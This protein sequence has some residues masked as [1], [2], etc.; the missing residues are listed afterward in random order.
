[1][2]DIIPFRKANAHPQRSFRELLERR[3]PGYVARLLAQGGPGQADFMAASDFAK[4]ILGPKG[5]EIQFLFEPGSKKQ[6]EVDTNLDDM[7]RHVAALAFIP[8]G[9]K[10]FGLHI[11]VIDGELSMEPVDGP[12][13]EF[14]HL[15]GRK[16]TASYYTPRELIECLL[17]TTLDPVLDEAI[18]GQ[19]S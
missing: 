15:S 11:Q 17:D 9:M 2:G 18:R 6:Q 12:A 14:M 13:G 5:D 10:L 4:Y 8:N 7:A 1:M 3:V 19:R 16:T